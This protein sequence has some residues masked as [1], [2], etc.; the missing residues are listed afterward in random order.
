MNKGTPKQ[1]TLADAFRPLTKK[2]KYTQSNNSNSSIDRFFQILAEKN[3]KRNSV[4]NSTILD[5]NNDSSEERFLQR[6]EENSRIRNNKLEKLLSKS[7][8]RGRKKMDVKQVENDNASVQSV[9]LLQNIR[10]IPSNNHEIIQIEETKKIITNPDN[11]HTDSTASSG[12]DTDET[13]W[14][15][16]PRYIHVSPSS[17]LTR[18]TVR[19][20]R[21]ETVG[22]SPSNSSST[23][24]S[25]SRKSKKSKSTSKSKRNRHYQK[26]RRL[27][28][29]I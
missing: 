25:K 14:S 13:R 26:S 21:T 9:I 28:V 12:Y 27:N 17:I 4:I 23:I 24:S 18:S 1:K 2:R 7:I 16:R 8:I 19:S 22:K 5:H 3:E 15:I 29:H 10:H 11:N 6:L 20:D